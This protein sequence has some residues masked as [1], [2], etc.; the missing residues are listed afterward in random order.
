MTTLFISDLHLDPTRPDIE[1]L[2]HRFLAGP[3]RRAEALYILGDL[4]E[5]WAGDDIDG[6]RHAG[7]LDA[8]RRLTAITPVR[9]MV[10]NR[11]FLLGAGFEAATGCRL[12]D[13]PQLID[14]DGVPTVL[15]HGDQLCTADI[16]YQRFRR[17][18]RNR[19][20]QRAYRSLPAHARA[21][22]VGNLRARTAARTQGKPAEITDVTPAA[23]V[24]LFRTTKARRLIHGHTHRPGVHA[25]TVDNI[26]RERIVLGDWYTQG[27]VLR[28]A[29]GRTQLARLPLEA[30]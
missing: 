15:S 17:L 24:E 27:S 29:A 7:T 11:D 13:D 21:R 8:L 14:L 2:F 22:L 28:C 9:V 18:V 5:T 26:A 16:G 19:W 4:F 20:L 23:V 10:G 30:D 6:V 25:L 12:L 1:A 3:A